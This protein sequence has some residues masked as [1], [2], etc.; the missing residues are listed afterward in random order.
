VADG[1][2]PG[3]AEGESNAATGASIGTLEVACP[4]IGAALCP[5]IGPTVFGA[6]TGTL[7]WLSFETGWPSIGT[8]VGDGTTT[9]TLGKEWPSIGTTV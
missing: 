9:G 5:S 3:M 7:G 1:T 8:K 2:N 6:A 4:S